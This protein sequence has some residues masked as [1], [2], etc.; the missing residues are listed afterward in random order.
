MAPKP[1]AVMKSRKGDLDAGRLAQGLSVGAARS[2]RRHHV[3]ARLV[4]VNQLVD[5]LL[6]NRAHRVAQIADAE[7]VHGHAESN[8]GRDLVAFGHGHVS[9]VVAEAGDPQVPGFRRP[10]AARVH[11]PIFCWTAASC[12]CP[13]TVL[14]GQPRRA[15]MWANSRSP[16]AAWFRFMKSMS[17]S[18]HGRSRLN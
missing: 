14:R 2:Q 8:L 18:V 3:V 11:V 12:Q 16:W 1:P 7:T 10:H 5:L 4:D 17:I 15:S 9:H 6:G 13:A